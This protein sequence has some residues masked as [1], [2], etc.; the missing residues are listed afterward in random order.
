MKG[1]QYQ[2]TSMVKTN[3]L[4]N[5]RQYDTGNRYRYRTGHTGYQ[6]GENYSIVKD[7]QIGLLTFYSH[8]TL[9]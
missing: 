5:R 6:Y 9:I 4:D 8:S 3:V 1:R 2:A 7:G